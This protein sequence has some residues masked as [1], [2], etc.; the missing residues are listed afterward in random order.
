[1]ARGSIRT[2][3]LAGGKEKRYDAILRTTGRQVW[4]T[5]RRKKDAEEWLDRNSTEVHDGTFRELNKATFREYAKHWRSTHL[6]PASFKPSTYNSY[7]SLFEHHILP[8]FA[9]YQMTAISSAE[10]NK[11]KARLL[12]SNLSNQSVRNILHLLSR[13]F[14]DALSDNYIKYSPMQGVK[15][16][17]ASKEKKGR[18]LALEE[19]NSLLNV[20]D[21]DTHLMVLTALLTGVRESELFALFWEDFDWDNRVFKICRELFWKFGKYQTRKAGEPGYVFVSPKSHHSVREIDLSPKLRKE[22]RKV[23]LK[24]TKSGLVFRTSKGTP[25]VPNNIYKRKFRPAL[26][27]AGIKGNVRFH[28]LRHTFGALKIEQGENP[29]YIQRQM[30]HSSIQVTFDIYGHLL[31]SRKPEAAARTDELVFGVAETL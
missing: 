5:F 2:R 18:A 22:L 9:P 8:E 13:F 25:F 10:I 20:L 7:C 23:Y 16:P 24:G 26:K 31:K 14:N 17:K 30:G 15:K 4:K 29:Y 1:M 28:D 3:Q 21:A 27:M 12:S 6:I 11:F 19:I